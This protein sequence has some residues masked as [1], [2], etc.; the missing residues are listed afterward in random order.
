LNNKIGDRVFLKIRPSQVLRTFKESKN[1]IRY[2]VGSRYHGTDDTWVCSHF[3]REVDTKTKINPSFADFQTTNLNL[4][5]GKTSYIEQVDEKGIFWEV[6]ITAP[7]ENMTFSLPRM[8]EE[9]F[10]VAGEYFVSC[11]RGK[12][13]RGGSAANVEEHLSF[14]IES[15]VEK[16]P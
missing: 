15:Y 1:D 8:P 11:E 13:S 4:S 2:H 14:E 6:M 16:M 10:T 7:S 12:T 9:S 3:N 5:A